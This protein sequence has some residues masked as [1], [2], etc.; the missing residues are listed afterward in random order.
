ME[1]A[2][3]IAQVGTVCSGVFR[4]WSLGRSPVPLV[5]VCCVFPW[6]WS[7]CSDP[8][9]RVAFDAVEERFLQLHDCRLRREMGNKSSKVR[10]RER[11]PRAVPAVSPLRNV[12]EKLEDKF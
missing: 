9:E 7:P 2:E 6:P 5:G 4:G 12:M 11:V 1:E 3:E 8:L 10:G